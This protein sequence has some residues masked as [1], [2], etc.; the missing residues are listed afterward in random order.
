MYFLSAKSLSCIK[1]RCI[2]HC[3]SAEKYMGKIC[4]VLL[5]NWPVECGIL[6]SHSQRLTSEVEFYTPNVAF[7]SPLEKNMFP[8]FKSF[9]SLFLCKAIVSP[10]PTVSRTWGYLDFCSRKTWI[11]IWIHSVIF[12]KSLINIIFVINVKKK[13]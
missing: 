13:N 12:K 7:K 10:L 5:L 9:S 4:R 1:R 6:S 2:S 11:R 8:F 3:R